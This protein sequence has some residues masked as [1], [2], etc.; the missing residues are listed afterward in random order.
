MASH[1]SFDDYILAK[2]KCILRLSSEEKWELK[3]M[4]EEARKYKQGDEIQNGTA[5]KRVLRKKTTLHKK[6]QNLPDVCFLGCS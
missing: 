2:G 4:S 5:K 6:K 1:P 3:V